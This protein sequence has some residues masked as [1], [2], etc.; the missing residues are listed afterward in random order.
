MSFLLK[1]V[2]AGVASLIASLA[3]MPLVIKL[4]SRKGWVVYPRN[5]RWHTR[6]T[7]L[8]GGIGIFAS[9]TV[10]VFCFNA[11]SGFVNWTIYIAA[12]VMFGIGLID[13]IKE[14]KP[15]VK[16]LAQIACSFV[17][18]Y[19]GY[20]FGGGLL[21]WAGIPLTFIWVI[22]ITNAINLLDNMDGL[23]GGISGIIAIISG[24]LGLLNNEF[25]L[26]LMAF[27]IAGATTGFLFYNFKPA[28]IFM[29]D[30][31]S[32]FLGFSLSFLSIAVQGKLGSSSAVLMLLIP[33]G[34]MAL[35]IMDTTLVT[36]KR[37]AAG[38]RIDQGGRDHT[39]HRLVALGLSEKKAVIVLYV[40]SAI[41]G[42]LCLLMYK[43]QVNNLILCVILLAVFS[44]AFSVLL[45]K[46]KVYNESEEKLSYLKMRGQ[47]T[48][49]NNFSLR[50]FMMHKKL[51]F[52]LFTDILIIYCSFLISTKAIHISLANDYVVLATFIC[53]KI[54]LLYISNLYYRLWRYMEVLEV[55]GYFMFITIATLILVGILFIK[56]K[57]NVYT[58]YFFMFDYLLTFT[59]IVFSRLFYRWLGEVIN[60][61]RN[62]EKKVMIYGAG[63]SGYLLI[64]EILQN[65][66]HELRP[67]GW[68]DDDESKHNMY[69]YGYKIYGGKDQ[70][71]DICS[72]VKP[73]IVLISTNAIDEDYEMIIKD[74][75]A[76]QNIGTGRFSLSIR[77]N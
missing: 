68:I 66:K 32:L 13:D 71:R 52:G 70:L 60:R 47:K 6:P 58:P 15:I 14:V 65:H 18:I 59:G 62:I 30:S 46:V 40:I 53:V 8:M 67:V 31:G 77:Y 9:F 76:E 56:G 16:L 54:S 5:D 33:I 25:T 10:A 72:K 74:I 51:I 50:F 61:N 64:K 4:A 69:L 28:R 17:L 49:D 12:L 75:L 22:G 44:I 26:A 73:D 23:A 42:V 7:A 34:L 21:G 19:H 20:T 43:F 55:A 38:R 3:I 45:S 63:D 41:W 57:M 24:V 11:I 35:P 2:L 37:I 36:I 29:G 27:A 48:D 39:S 1:A